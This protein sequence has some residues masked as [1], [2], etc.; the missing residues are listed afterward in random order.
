M[1]TVIFPFCTIIF[2]IA[3]C[4]HTIMPDTEIN[5]HYK[6]IEKLSQK[7]EAKILLYK[8]NLTSD[9]TK[10]SGKSII[11][12]RDSIKFL[13]SQD[14]VNIVLPIR[15]IDRIEFNSGADGGVE[16]MIPGIL[17]GTIAGLTTYDIV[18]KIKNNGK[19][20][21]DNYNPV[22]HIPYISVSIPI[23]M[24]LG[25]TIGKKY[26]KYVFIMN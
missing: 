7:R 15:I 14:M 8:K 23:G 22:A 1:K 12:Y 13:C 10:Y 5:E 9:F 21:Y 18:Y 25:Y 20:V 11:F 17:F 3:N 4:T 19:P 24:F 2:F 26:G 6:K 16:G